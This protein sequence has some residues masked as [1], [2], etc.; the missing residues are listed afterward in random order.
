MAQFCLMIKYLILIIF[1]FKSVFA[2]Q[3]DCKF[4]EVYHDG[5][6][7]NGQVLINDNNIR[8]E[9]FDDILYTIIKNSNGI[10][11]VKNYQKKKS[12]RV[13][14]PLIREIFTIYDDF[15]N[16]KSTY[17]TD[18]FEV[19]VYFSKKHIFISR[20]SVLSNRVNVS[21]YF[22]DCEIK[23]INEIYFRVDPLHDYIY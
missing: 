23:E 4:E 17:T 21:I 10:F 7:Q 20:V 2:L 16:L 13:Y 6:I 19:N 1:P 11:L 22:N 5:S 15:P 3:I 9:Y 8:Y 14:D 12:E 18:N